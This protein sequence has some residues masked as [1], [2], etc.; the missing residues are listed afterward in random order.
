MLGYTRRHLFIALAT[1]LCIASIS[2]VALA[3]FFPSPPSKF[4]IAGSFPGGHY[5]RLAH[6]Y[7]EIL[8]RSHVTVEVRTTAGAVDNLKLLQDPNSGIQIGFSQGG[9]SNGKQ[10]PD[11]L[12]LGR[13]NHQPFWLFHRVTE[14]LDDLTELKG[15]RIALGPVGSG[16]R[17]VTEKILGISG[18]NSE[19]ATLMPLAARNA[20]DAL[21]EGKIDALFLVFTPEEP[22]LQSMLKDPRIRPMSFTKAEAITRIFPTLVRLVLPRGAIDYERNIPA[23]DVTII[24]A[25][26]VVLVRKEINPALIDLLMQTMLEAHGEAGLFQ[27]AGDF[28]TH[29]DPEFPMAETAVD[30][31]KNGPSFL[32]RY[33]PFWV[34]HYAQRS[35]AVLTAVIAIALPLFSFAPKLYRGFVAYRLGSLYRRLRVIEASLQK[36]ASSSE[37]AALEAELESVDRAI[38]LLGVPM[39]HSDL[40]FSIESHLD[41]VRTR[42]ELRRA[43]LR[44][45][46]PSAA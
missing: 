38:H 13:I 40:Y 6:E 33:F 11:L 34:T 22:V 24:A 44:G 9:I 27:K 42:L 41:L 37:F 39:Q 5:E 12:S 10:A 4:V 15:K 45:Q 16:T 8:A 20:Y 35:I 14:P 17:A 7:K 25:T 30:F 21:V 36:G 43:R 1:I 28:P 19:T 18:V 2:W 31:Y 46:L 3:Y 26:N 23:A 32:H 29:T